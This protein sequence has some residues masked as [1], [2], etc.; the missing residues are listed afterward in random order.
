MISDNRSA[1]SSLRRRFVEVRS[2]TERLVQPLADEDCVV[3]SMPDVSPTK[4]HMAH[5]TWFFE[6]FVLRPHLEGYEVKHPEYEFLFNSYYNTVGPQFS[7]PRRGLLT[8]PTVSGVRE[9]RRHVDEAVERLLDDRGG[10]VSTE[11]TRLIELGIQHEQQHQE[12]ILM[13]IKHV[14]SCNPLLPPYRE[15]GSGPESDSPGERVWMSVPEGLEMLG[16]SGD[17]FAYDNESPRHRVFLQGFRIASRPVTNAEFLEF[18]EA[19]GYEDPAPWLADGWACARD[20]SWEGPLYWSR[21]E[22]GWHEFTLDGPRPLDHHAPV[23]HVSYYEAEA[24]ASWAGVRLPTEGE[25]ERVA[26]DRPI[27]G[28]F[29]ESGRLHPGPGPTAGDGPHQ[30]YGDL[31]EWTR[32]P[33]VPYPGFEA[34]EGAVGEYNG[35]FMCNQQVLR[36]GSCVTPRSH[37]RP[38]YRNFFYPHCRWQFAGLRLAADI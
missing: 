21:R 32:S 17:G 7:R 33:Y 18:V 19:G 8:R 30:L 11:V 37:I 2:A 3:Q 22:N 29:V 13:D 26:R 15:G 27:E 16:H 38:T 35:K 20:Q 1:L 9:Y 5:V 25:W 31:W 10:D 34:P 23:C 12:L 14:L 28:N 4:W 36:G 24:F 6:T